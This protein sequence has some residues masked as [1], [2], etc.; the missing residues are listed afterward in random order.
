MFSLG[1]QTLFSFSFCGMCVCSRVHLPIGVHVC[2][3][4]Q[5][6][7][8][9]G[10]P[11]VPSHLVSCVMCAQVHPW[12]RMHM[13]AHACRGWR[14]ILAISLYHFFFETRSSQNLELA[15]SAAA[16]KPQGPSY[17]CPSGSAHSFIH[18]FTILRGFWRIK[19]RAWCLQGK[20]FY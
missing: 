15:D 17:L 18:S 12:T 13:C 6:A 3:A 20:C 8:L 9:A 7:A 2:Y 14:L 5:R 16:C 1:S 19:L 4:H 11:H 10:L